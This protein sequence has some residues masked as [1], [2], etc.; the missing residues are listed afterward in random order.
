MSTERRTTKRFAVVNLN[1]FNRETDDE[2][3]QVINLSEGGLFVVGSN[4]MEK[5]EELGLRIPFDHDGQ[6][7]NFDVNA[8]V[9]WCTRE[10]LK[11]EVYNIG[12]E[13]AAHSKEQYDFLMQMIRLYGE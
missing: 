11:D 12:M 5:G 1:L 13:F 6:E 2:I 4:E 8:K 7:I 9:A 3:G 10:N